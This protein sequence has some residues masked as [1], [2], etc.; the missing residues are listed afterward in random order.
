MAGQIQTSNCCQMSWSSRHADPDQTK[1]APIRRGS[2]CIT[3]LRDRLWVTEDRRIRELR[4]QLR[5]TE[6]RRIGP[7]RAP[8]RERKVVILFSCYYSHTVL[9]S[10]GVVVVGWSGLGEVGGV[11]IFVCLFCLFRYNIA[12]PLRGEGGGGLDINGQYPLNNM[13]IFYRWPL[14]ECMS[15]ICSYI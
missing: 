1:P 4:D 11:G 7:D 10:Y 12:W 13:E 2:S 15:K 8:H 6:D 3:E 9:F 5:V 14:T